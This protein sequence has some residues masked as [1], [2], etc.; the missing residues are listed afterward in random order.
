MLEFC[1]DDIFWQCVKMCLLIIN[2]PFHS[3]ELV[4]YP[5][6]FQS[7]QWIEYVNFILLYSQI[8]CKMQLHILRLQLFWLPS[9][10]YLRTEMFFGSFWTRRWKRISLLHWKRKFVNEQWRIELY[11]V[12]CVSIHLEGTN[13]FHEAWFSRSQFIIVYFAWHSRTEYISV[14]K[15]NDSTDYNLIVYTRHIKWLCLI[16]NHA[17]WLKPGELLVKKRKTRLIAHFI[18]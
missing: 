14:V 18:S 10:S 8:K 9:I 15:R 6:N 5:Y 13:R 3:N 16:A 2:T 1:L 11:W 17:Y 12:H 7:S 4:I